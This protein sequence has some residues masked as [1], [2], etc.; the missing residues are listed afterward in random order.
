[1]FPEIRSCLAAKDET[2]SN[3]VVGFFIRDVQLSSCTVQCLRVIVL[4]VHHRGS[5]KYAMRVDSA[6]QYIVVIYGG[7]KHGRTYMVVYRTQ[8]MLSTV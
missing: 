5:S 3:L 7:K 8:Y 2:E 4:C 6:V 1:M